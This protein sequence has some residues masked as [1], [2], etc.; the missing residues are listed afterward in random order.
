LLLISGIGLVTVKE[1]GRK[2]GVCIAALKIARLLGLYGF[3]IIVIVPITTQRL[4][5]MVEEMQQNFPPGQRANAGAPIAD[6]AKVMGT[7]MTV[8]FVAMIV[9]GAIYPVVALVV[10]TRPSVKAACTMPRPDDYQE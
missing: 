7:M 2:L 6:M 3:S 5:Q 8:S 1:W 9:L 10:L 4:I